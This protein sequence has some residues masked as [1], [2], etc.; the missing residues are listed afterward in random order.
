MPERIVNE[1]IVDTAKATKALAD[2]SKKFNQYNKEL[3]KTAAAQD[4]QNKSASQARAFFDKLA[5]GTD[6]ATK[7]QKQL[8]AATKAAT[9][10][11]RKNTNQNRK[12]KKSADDLGVSW[13][14]VK[15]IFA[16]QI[17]FRVLS[18]LT[19][20]MRDSIG[21]AQ[22]LGIKLAEAITIAPGKLTL[23]TEGVAKLGREIREL[24]QS[25]GVDQVELATA[26]YQVYS[27]QIGDA[28]EST[29]FLRAA[30]L[31]AKATVTDTANS[32][33]LLSG[34]INS[35]ELEASEAARVSDIF[36]KAVELGRFRIDDIANSMGRVNPIAAQL[37]IKIEEVAA[38]LATLTI[39]GVSPDKALTQLL[40][41]MLKMVK[42]SG[43]L[44]KALTEIGFANIKQATSTLGLVGTLKALVATTDGTVE[45]LGRLFPRVRGIQGVL[46]LVNDEGKRFDSIFKEIQDTADGATRKFAEF[47]LAT[48]AEE[49]KRNIQTIKNLFV[50]DFG[51][52]FIST[53][54]AVLEAL[55]GIP[56][57]VNKIKSAIVILTVAMAVLT[58]NKLAIVMLG[59][60]SVM[61]RASSAA[62][63]LRFAMLKIPFVVLVAGATAL[64]FAIGELINF[65]ALGGKEAA[66][67]ADEQEALKQSTLEL[68][69]VIAASAGL[70][71]E[72]VRSA[73]D[74][75]IDAV[76]NS[77]REQTKA[78]EEQGN[79]IKFLGQEVTEDLLDELDRRLKAFQDFADDSSTA[80]IDASK[81][82]ARIDKTIARVRAAGEQADFDQTL[83]G[84]SKIQQQRAKD[85]RVLSLIKRARTAAT[86][87]EA[88]QLLRVA[89][90]EARG[91]RFAKIATA[92][93][94]KG[95]EQ[96]K[97]EIQKTAVIL[98]G[99]S[100]TIALAVKQMT[101]LADEAKR[102]GEEVANAVDKLD[103]STAFTEGI[104]LDAAI[105]G[106][107]KVQSD[108]ETVVGAAFDKSV[109]GL[110]EGLDNMFA[111]PNLISFKLRNV[112]KEIN[113]LF[114]EREIPVEIRLKAGLLGIN[115][116]PDATF[117]TILEGLVGTKEAQAKAMAGL[118]GR[119]VTGV[120][121]TLE[122]A[123]Q[124]I[125]T[126]LSA[127]KASF[128]IGAFIPS[129]DPES[130]ATLATL[131]ELIT[132][133]RDA[134]SVEKD[135]DI[136]ILA[137]DTFSKVASTLEGRLNSLREQG[138]DKVADSFEELVEKIQA[139]ENTIARDK[140][141]GELDN[142]IR[143]ALEEFLRLNQAIPAATQGLKN[144]GTAAEPVLIRVNA[145]GN[146]TSAIGPK[147]QSGA[148][149]AVSALQ[150]IGQNALNQ[151][152][153]VNALADALANLAAQRRAAATVATGGQIPAFLAGGGPTQ[154]RGTD[155]VSVQAAPGEFFVNA[156]SSRRFIPELTAIN[157]GRAPEPRNNSQTTN[158]SFSGDININVPAG[159]S[160][161]GRAVAQDIRRELRRKTSSL[162]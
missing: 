120:V 112:T 160:V 139:V 28:R 143:G 157:Q 18:S 67:L 97:T 80:I 76:I 126:Q 8:T 86:A 23:S 11:G 121:T 59:I 21:V 128:G 32:V 88:N 45:A 101:A 78:Y 129:V 39:K 35:Y 89:E 111:D 147:A 10:A 149:Q 127:K 110:R 84:M 73:S 142:D 83:K 64:G 69:T 75:Q 47:I 161:N 77:I 57:A 58:A 2:L 63:L 71:L 79:R 105:V 92:A 137:L 114:R 44:T 48:E 94:I 100:P 132:S 125:E 104:K 107:E 122:Q 144:I 25:F 19:N 5:G 56:G 51:K 106:L 119:I 74:A 27:N 16:G 4:K 41:V 34:V 90:Q 65:Y 136:S 153:K 7:S 9:A 20:Q 15:R 24:S 135:E 50:E 152:P 33:D 54:N 43:A 146:E 102:L 134:L 49:F 26:A 3:V 108:I 117:E 55:G 116:G 53:I 85:A 159:T 154:S 62:V 156:A 133:V 68:A 31:F 115:V 1:I 151:I 93:R 40:A 6:R 113:E 29:E 138:L 109:T 14:S 130:L 95:L 72:A 155:T 91:G 81:R 17:I 103:F 162:S 131:A 22:E 118:K 12:Q 123:S 13:T 66:R 99:L 46:G 150:T 61:G 37:G 30:V 70:G 96:Q 87:E 98:K 42:P 140:G 60:V 82:T 52:I 145:L 158:N 38:A 148:Q 141:I 36:T 124:E